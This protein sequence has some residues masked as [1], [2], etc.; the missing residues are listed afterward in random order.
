[1]TDLNAAA[2]IVGY[3]DGGEEDELE[4]SHVHLHA[5]HLRLLFST[6]RPRSS[7]QKVCRRRV[8]VSSSSF[9]RLDLNMA[10]TNYLLPPFNYNER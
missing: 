2:M 10:R 1:M 6:Q 9:K 5:R 3:S 8:F 7:G 4:I